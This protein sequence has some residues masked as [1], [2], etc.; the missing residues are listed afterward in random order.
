M[1]TAW[2]QRVA[3][4]QARRAPPSPRVR[5]DHRRIYILPSAAGY[6]F[7]LTVVLILLAAINYQNS[8]AYALAFTLGALFVVAILHTYRN[9][10]G[11]LILAEAPAPVF[12]GEP[13]CVAVGLQSQGRE[14]HALHLGWSAAELQRFDL[15]GDGALRQE[16]RLDT[17][18]RGWQRVPRLRLET[19]FPLGLLRAWSWV[20]LGQRV[21]VYPRPLAGPLPAGNGQARDAEAHDWQVLGTGVDDF[22][23]LQEYRPGDSWRRLH[24]KAFSKGQALL[25]KAFA[26]VH[27]RDPALSLEQLDGPLETRLS[28]LC[29]WV[30][31]LSRQGQ[32]FS[33]QVPGA[34]LAAASGDDHRQACLRALAL[35]ETWP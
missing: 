17:H 23:G 3:A 19:R 22:Q 13:A 15:E 1:N 29:F 2:G 16:L 25:I 35:V 8:M 9:L 24:W 12:A 14:Y 30:L 27:G 32:A 10:G 6:G 5:L 20:D 28:L 31:E 21:L 33:L 7:L 4:W 26:E 34:T 18:Q 11:L